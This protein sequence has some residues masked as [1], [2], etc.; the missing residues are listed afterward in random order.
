MEF[1]FWIKACETMHLD[2]F[3]IVSSF[4]VA[5]FGP[6]AVRQNLCRAKLA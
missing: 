2:N 5:A 1:S 3:I 4:I 6:R